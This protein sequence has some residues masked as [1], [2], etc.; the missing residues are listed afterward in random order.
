[1]AKNLAGMGLWFFHFSFEQISDLPAVFMREYRDELAFEQN[2]Y[3]E[4]LQADKG[5]P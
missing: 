2:S 1:M 4:D 5:Q 3:S